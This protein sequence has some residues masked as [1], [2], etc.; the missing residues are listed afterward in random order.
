MLRMTKVLRWSMGEHANY[1][2]LERLIAKANHNDPERKMDRRKLKA[3]VEGQDV[4]LSLR[5]LAA[6]DKYLS[7]FGESLADKPLFDR[8]SHLGSLAA[9]GDVLFLLGGYPRIDEER[10]DVSCWDLRSMALMLRGLEKANPG[11][12]MDIQEVLF[13]PPE[14]EIPQLHDK[15]SSLCCIGSP[16]AC[17]AADVMLD[18][19]F[20]QSS[21]A[22]RGGR[23]PPVRFVWGAAAESASRSRFQAKPETIRTVAPDLARELAV[24]EAWGALQ[25]QDK[26]YALRSKNQQSWSDYGV[27]LLQRR[28]HGQ[29]WVIVAGL[30][31]PATY[32]C[33]EAVATELKGSVAE[34]HSGPSPIRWDVV[35]ATVTRTEAVGDP[36]AVS[37][38]EVVGSGTIPGAGR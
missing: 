28:A 6:L 33:A 17:P 35:K 32:A 27:V 24:G 23:T 7:L 8:P 13:P 19:M 29:V 1:A 5:E 3:L 4:T 14:S 12:H 21:L 9:K 38:W 36:R 31:G 25:I 37:S 20:S 22:L 11:L 16:R 15:K 18:A 2:E 10:N 34:E 26:F 30:S